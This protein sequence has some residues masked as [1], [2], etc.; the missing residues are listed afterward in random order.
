V[1][2]TVTLVRQGEDTEMSVTVGVIVQLD[3]PPSQSHFDERE[4]L[5]TAKLKS[6]AEF[7]ERYKTSEKTLIA[8]ALA[9][10]TGVEGFR[11]KYLKPFDCQIRAL[12]GKNLSADC[13]VGFSLAAFK[14]T[15]K[16]VNSAI[17]P[18]EQA[19]GWREVSK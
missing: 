3:A 11:Q 10:V 6:C 14:A 4:L 7:L 5:R 12:E 17:S 16:A 18:D 19:Y 1:E 9:A 15:A 13:T 8:C 2:S